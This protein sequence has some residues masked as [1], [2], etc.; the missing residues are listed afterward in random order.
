MAFSAVLTGTARSCTLTSGSNSMVVSSAA[1]LVV[2]ATIQGTGVPTGSRIGTISGTTVTMVTAAGAA[3]NATASGAQNLIFS[4]VIGSLL[5][6]SL[7]ASGDYATPQNIYNAGFGVME[8][9]TALRE[10]YFPGGLQ[11]KWANIVSGAVFDFLNWTL[12]FGPNGW[13]RFQESSIVGELRGGYLVNG[14]QFIKTVG[15]TFYS[16]NWNNG[17]A[18]GS[19]MFENLSGTTNQGIFRMHNMRVVE[20]AG[21]NAAPAFTSAR[22]TMNV[23]NMIL[24]YQGDSAGA[25]AGVG[26]AF[27][28]LKNTYLV[29][30]NGGIGATNGTNFATWDGLIYTGNYGSSPQHKFST[31]QG[32]VLDGYSPQVLST[33]FLGGFNS[34]TLEIYSNINLSTAGW[35]LENLKTKYLRYFGPITLQFPRRVT[36]E[37]ND[38]TAANLTGVTLYI[39]SGSTSVVNAVQAGDYNA[40]T[41]ALNL[42]WTT[43]AASYRLCDSFV[44]TIEQVAQFRKFGY[45]EQ[46]TPYSLN[47]SSYSQPIF[48]LSDT[49]A[50]ASIE[51]A[52]SALTTVG[53]NWTAKTITPTASLNYDQINARMAWELAQTTGSTNVDPRT[54]SGLNLTLATGWTLV[55]NTGVTISAGTAITYLK[56]LTITLNGTGKITG[57]YGTSAGDSSTL[58]V[59]AVT[60]TG[61]VGIWHPSTSATE[62]FQTNNSGSAASYDVYY[63]PGSVGL[64]KN[65]ARELYSYQRVAGSITLAGGLNVVSFVDIPDVG[66]TQATLA[67]VNAYTAIEGPSKFYDRT[68]AFRLTEQGIKLGQLVTRSGTALEIQSGFSHVINNNPGPGIVYQVIGSVITSKSST[69]AADTKYF[70][71]IATPPA[72]IT[73]A[74]TEVI[75]IA[76]EDA[77]GD[78]QITIQAAGVSTFEIWKITDATNPDNYASGTLVATVGIGTWRFLSAN[79][80]KFVVRDTTTNYRVVVEAEKGI[81]TAELF[82]GAQVQLAQAAEVSQINTKV[83]VL[84][85]DMTAV[86]GGAFNGAT[87]SLS[88]IRSAVDTIP[89]GVWA[90]VLETG[91]SALALMRLMASV[92]LGKVSG[93]GTTTET[94]RDINDTKDRVIATVDEAGNRTDITRDPS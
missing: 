61:V 66:I 85:N 75:T 57:L 59:Q 91:H 35:G 78:S 30:V 19:S 23:E 16:N 31:S 18:G 89:A 86:K 94:F 64:V 74:T 87:D 54:L 48:M 22:M 2:G 50:P 73:A 12:E 33:Q 8:T 14:T 58:R 26:A 67:T 53:V 40:N 13:W 90:Y 21:S 76:R 82:F 62:L 52:T 71:E 51:A 3:S 88:A 79:G 72:T 44:D 5:T 28:T 10:L 55:V 27:G 45:L 49:Y 25:N 4:S 65:Y 77:N 32:Y 60:A 92:L 46:S 36:F 81:Y 93:A 47:L 39:R 42:V 68:A 38:S 70:T 43:N 80:F 17:A 6:V 24:D 84:Q 29:K 41:Q 11:V 37:F 83:D 20:I 63:P 15:P 34:V 1:Q 69:Y 9:N 56:V 7:S